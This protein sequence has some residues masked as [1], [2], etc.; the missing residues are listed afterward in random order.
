MR[1]GRKRRKLD[2]KVPSNDLSFGK[3]KHYQIGAQDLTFEDQ[4]LAQTY[5]HRNSLPGK[6]SP[7]KE[8][9]SLKRLCSS[10]IAHGAE[11]IM[12]YH[13]EATN[14][15]WNIW[16]PVWHFILKYEKDTPAIFELFAE[17]FAQKDDFYCHRI[18]ANWRNLDNYKRGVFIELN[19]IN[20]KHRFETFYQHVSLSSLFSELHHL[21]FESL[22][23]L[24]LQ[25][26]DLT[27]RNLCLNVLSSLR[28]LNVSHANVNDQML[29]SWSIS[30]KNGNLKNLCCLILSH[31]NLENVDCIL[32]S[33]LQYFETEIVVKDPHWNKSTDT[34]LSVLSDG[35]KF[36]QIMGKEYCSSQIIMDYKVSNI[37]GS[38]SLKKL[39]KSRSQSSNPSRR[40]FQYIRIA[41]PEANTFSKRTKPRPHARAKKLDVKTFFDI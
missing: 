35:L 18:P 25:G 21:K 16:R 4:E 39:W 8:A 23:V 28:Y 36:R 1:F 41:D 29:K 2:L 20:R 34:K 32:D 7:V 22:V 10:Q 38:E 26:I 30:M 27:K 40:I 9:G 17:Y 11:C 3:L 6:Q 13:I 37:E 15:N 12:R 31:N 33:P 19:S 14:S 5:N 24:S